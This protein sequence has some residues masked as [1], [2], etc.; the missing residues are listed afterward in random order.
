MYIVPFI[1]FIFSTASPSY[2]IAQEIEEIGIPFHGEFCGP[3]IP[4]LEYT[5][6]QD[7]IYKLKQIAPIDVIDRSCKDHDICY[8]E[9]GYFHEDCDRKLIDDLSNVLKLKTHDASCL[10]LSIGIIYYFKLSNLPESG[11]G[12]YA[13]TIISGLVNQGSNF[14]MS[15]EVMVHKIFFSAYSVATSPIALFYGENPLEIKDVI[16]KI[17]KE[18]GVFDY[19]PGRYKKCEFSDN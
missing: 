19:Y 8:V 9:R 18:N 16:K 11:I 12:N 4:T 10:A 5:N 6:K 14:W 17:Y 2:T 7:H 13:D 15:T 3:N 1:I